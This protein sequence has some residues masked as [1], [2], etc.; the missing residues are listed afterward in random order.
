MTLKEKLSQQPT[1]QAPKKRNISGG[2]VVYEGPSKLDPSQNIVGILTMKTTNKKTG[3]MAQLWILHKDIKPTEA[4]KEGKDS[5]VCGNCPLRH[6]NG[7][8][9]Y[10]V[11]FQAPA[12]IFQAYKKGSYSSID[13]REYKNLLEGRKIRFGAYGDPA[14]LPMEILTSLKAVASN[15]TSYTHQW[16]TSPKLKGL[17]MAS[18]DNIDEARQAVENGWRYFRVANEDSEILANEVICPNVT[19]GTSCADCGL[20]NGKQG[21]KD[22]RKS[23]VIPVHGNKKSKFK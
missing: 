1:K 23:I 10:V 6:F 7:G 3:D 15:N 22:K 19:H 14:A 8:A 11:L 16:K 13:P 9:C 21:D 5:A 17:S 2:F 12:S 4:S 20:C 18:V